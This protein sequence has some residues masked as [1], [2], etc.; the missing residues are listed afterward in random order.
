MQGARASARPV[1]W[2]FCH[3]VHDRQR[4]SA[5]FSDYQQVSAGVA[6]EAAGQRHMVRTAGLATT[7]TP[8][9]SSVAAPASTASNIACMDGEVVWWTISS[10]AITR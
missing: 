6:E 5:A 10:L 7:S 2:L 9:M 1:P 4:P 3:S 8:S